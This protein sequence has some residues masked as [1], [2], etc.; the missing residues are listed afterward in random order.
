[1]STPKAFTMNSA[2]LNKRLKRDEGMRRASLHFAEDLILGMG[3]QERMYILTQ[4]KVQESS[5]RNFGSALNDA[6]LQGMIIFFSGGAHKDNRFIFA[7]ASFMC[8]LMDD[9]LDIRG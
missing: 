8:D 6:Q 9:R 2:E 5:I 1:M 7:L 4:K 3:G